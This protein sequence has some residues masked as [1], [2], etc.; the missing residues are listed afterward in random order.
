MSAYKFKI[1]AGH[2]SE[3]ARGR[4]EVIRQLPETGGEHEYR[5]KSANEAYEHVAR[6]SEL[7][8]A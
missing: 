4:F 2:Q 1:V 5:I 6:E 3:L 8:K 7:D